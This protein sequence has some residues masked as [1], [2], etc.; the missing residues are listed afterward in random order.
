[1]AGEKKR[2]CS[3]TPNS[4]CRRR[5]L[6]LHPE[7]ARKSHYLV[8]RARKPPPTFSALFS[9]GPVQEQLFATVTPAAPVVVYDGGRRRG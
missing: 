6:G 4:V 2:S 1:M 5:I 9:I 7:G 3:G 8:E